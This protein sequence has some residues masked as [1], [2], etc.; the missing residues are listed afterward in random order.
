MQL[1]SQSATPAHAVSE[2]RVGRGTRTAAQRDGAE[3]VAR[4]ILPMILNRCTK[5]FSI[6]RPPGRKSIVTT[7][8]TGFSHR[9]TN[10]PEATIRVSNAKRAALLSNADGN[11]EAQTHGHDLARRLRH[12]FR[13]VDHQPSRLAQRRS[14]KLTVIKPVLNHAITLLS[15]KQ[16]H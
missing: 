4:K 12:S 3:V 5:P 13:H 8:G 2:R 15:G 14:R 16:D 11:A 10:T 7:G 6:R 9:E 1:S